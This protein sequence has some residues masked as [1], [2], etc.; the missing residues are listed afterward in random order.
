L[1]DRSTILKELK[2][3]ASFTLRK[4]DYEDIIERIKNG[5][6]IL[7]DLVNQSCGLEP[8]R[9][10]R[11]QARLIK[12]IRGLARSLFQAIQNATTCRCLKP[13]EVCLELVPRKAL[14]LPGDLEDNI[15]KDFV[16][17][18]AFGNHKTFP[19]D[20]TGRTSD[21]TKARRWEKF[22][23]RLGDFTTK[24][25]SIPE[26][27]C[28]IVATPASKSQRKV[29]WS[30]ATNTSTTLTTQTLLES[31][32]VVTSLPPAATQSNRPLPDICL[33]LSKPQGTRVTNCHG[34][35]NDTDR[36]FGLYP[37]K[38]VREIHDTITL[39]QLLSKNEQFNW[40][41]DCIQKLKVALAITT[42]ILHLYKTPWLGRTVTLDDFVFFREDASLLS[43]PDTLDRPFIAKG[44]TNSQDASVVSKFKPV[45]LMVLSLGL[46]LTQIIIGSTVE[47]LDV[48]DTVDMN[49]NTIVS[50]YEMGNSFSD[51]VLE[52]GGLSYAAVVKWC[53]SN[54]FSLA[55]LEN[56]NFCQT[57]YN[58]VVA[59]I[60][61]DVGYLEAGTL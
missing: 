45:N 29:A 60:E 55:N 13:Y 9:Q 50:K 39:R 46:L 44:I 24:P 1:K 4:K 47:E 23:L 22:D 59:R 35:I 38:E 5:N 14:I 16:F 28:P 61:E 37:P 43:G 36:E 2:R 53:L 10:Q 11:S 17:H 56:E 58:E 57:F 8:S 6:S 32:K 20:E 3:G 34:Y 51:R 12:L 42:N 18:V 19:A 27:T 40:E 33:D 21:L 26:N 48:K 54:V 31:S 15:A 41:F 7:H 49:M 25:L 52:N 30:Q